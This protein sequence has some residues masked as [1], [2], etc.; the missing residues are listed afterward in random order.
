MSIKNSLQGKVNSSLLCIVNP[1][2]I[3]AFTKAYELILVLQ[4]ILWI[5]CRVFFSQRKLRRNKGGIYLGTQ[6]H[7]IMEATR[8]LR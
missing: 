8:T 4:F 5:S 7:F 3:E 6:M 1:F 2:F